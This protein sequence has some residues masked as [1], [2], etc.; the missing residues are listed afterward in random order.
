MLHPEIPM[1]IFFHLCSLFNSMMTKGK[2]GISYFFFLMH[3]LLHTSK[4]VKRIDLWISG[5]VEHR[6]SLSLQERTSV[7]L[8]LL[9]SFPSYLPQ[10]RGMEAH[11][12]SNLISYFKW[13]VDTCVWTVVKCVCAKS[14]EKI[15][16]QTNKRRRISCYK[17]KQN[18]K[19]ATQKNTGKFLE[20]VVIVSWLNAYI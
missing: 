3:Y 12:C 9:L 13:Q 7:T 8:T 19:R 17:T 2:N 6:T 5:I 16:K 15:S 18:K 20:V 14:A 11:L 1:L 10:D 4:Y